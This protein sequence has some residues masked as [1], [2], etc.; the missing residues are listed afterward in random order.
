MIRAEIF[1][2]SLVAEGGYEWKSYQKFSKQRGMG[3]GMGG[4]KQL[5]YFFNYP[6]DVLTERQL[7]GRRYKVIDPFKDPVFYTEFAKIKWGDR[8]AAVAFANQYGALNANICLGDHAEPLPPGVRLGR[9]NTHVPADPIEAWT[10]GPAWLRALIKVWKGTEDYHKEVFRWVPIGGEDGPHSWCWF[11][12]ADDRRDTAPD[13]IIETPVYKGLHAERNPEDEHTRQFPPDYRYP[14]TGM[15]KMG[16]VAR[17]FLMQE[18]THLIHGGIP[19]LH[20]SDFRLEAAEPDTNGITWFRIVPDSM[21]Q[22]IFI[23]FAAAVAGNEKHEQCPCGR[24]FE[25]VPQDKGRKQFCSAACK[26]KD[27]RSR[28]ARAEQL[29]SDGMD[30]KQIR[31]EID[32]PLKTIKKWLKN[33]KGTK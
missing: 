21:F 28:K 14:W 17:A 33:R 27:Y 8:E 5:Q 32:T 6:H 29:G 11:P 12:D 4:E 2:R 22:A 20:C 7:S 18:L 31:L 23:Q 16:D 19:N 10:L 30:P 25:L 9:R 24:W 1:Y 26:M 3:K 15:E 13:F